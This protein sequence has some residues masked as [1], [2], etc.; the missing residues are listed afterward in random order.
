[1]QVLE[2]E[3]CINSPT[4]FIETYVKILTLDDG[5]QPFK[6]WDYQHDMVNNY[7]NNQF[8]ISLT[9]RQMG[10]SVVV[11]GVILHHALF[12]NDWRIAILANKGDHAKTI[13]S[14]VKDMYER[15]PKWLQQGVVEWNKFSITLGNGTEVIAAATTSA[16][17]RGKSIN[18]LYLDEF[19]F[20]TNDV[21]FYTS[22]YPVISGGNT[23]KVIITSTPNG[24][25]LFHK[26]YTQAEQNRNEFTPL[27]ILWDRHPHRTEEWR[28][29]TIR[30]IGIAQF[31]QE[32]L[33]AFIG[34]GNTLIE[35]ETLEYLVSQTPIHE[36]N[37]MSV[38]EKPI[39]NHQY[40][41]TVDPAEGTGNDYSA[42]SVIDTT[43]RRFKVV[44]TYANNTIKPGDFS[45]IVHKLSLRYNKA[46]LIVENNSIGSMVCRELWHTYENEGLLSTDGRD[47]I[48]Y[49]SNTFGVRQTKRTKRVGC[50]VLKLLIESGDLQ[51]P[52]EQQIA[53][54][55]TFSKQGNSGTYAA[56]RGKH[57][58]RVMTLVLFAWFS[59]TEFFVNDTD[60][61]VISGENDESIFDYPAFYC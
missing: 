30:N 7:Y 12:N 56:I 3:K 20:V 52:D 39:D 38:F 55:T 59:Q 10:K 16:S 8:S 58:D 48:T 49:S 15:L 46:Y 36:M 43:T 26:L 57:D 29:K 18:L 31:R 5:I 47:G 11:A 6:L 23:A 33:C 42:I 44:C 37:G 60:I 54:L 22:T 35:G 40:V 2:F 41:V 4:Y 53:E 1:M 9:A 51:T 50:R 21:E 32:F 13:L 24:M 14:I 61:N 28:L 19:A 25:N 45:F 17:I 27:K 34:S